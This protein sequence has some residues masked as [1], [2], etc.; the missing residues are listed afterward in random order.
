MSG[1]NDYWITVRCPLCGSGEGVGLLAGVIMCARCAEPTPTCA[2]C[3]A[4]D[5]SLKTY[6]RWQ[7][8]LCR[9]CRDAA[10]LVEIV[11]LPE[12]PVRP[13]P[14]QIATGPGVD[15]D[16]TGDQMWADLYERSFRARLDR[17]NPWREDGAA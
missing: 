13:R 6:E 14:A 17:R 16:P 15:L 10:A 3:G 12:R 11:A 7:I 8:V 5:R 4:T 9:P 1:V 2:A